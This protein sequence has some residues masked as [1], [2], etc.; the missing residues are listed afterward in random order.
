MKAAITATTKLQCQHNYSCQFHRHHFIVPQ[1][2]NAI[3]IVNATTITRAN[4]ITIVPQRANAIAIVDTI[5]TM[6][7]Y[8]NKYRDDPLLSAHQKICILMKRD[9][10]N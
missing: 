7:Q 10:W 8:Q 5:T 2:A 3:T 6:F 4:S 1:C 9:L